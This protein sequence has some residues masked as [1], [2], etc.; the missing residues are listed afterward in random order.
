MD[1]GA[2]GVEGWLGT[3][4]QSPSGRLSFP[5]QTVAW[6]CLGLAPGPWTRPC[7]AE[8]AP[9][10]LPACTAL[11]WQS[12]NG[13]PSGREAPSFC[14]TREGNP[15]ACRVSDGGVFCHHSCPL[16]SLL[17]SPPACGSAGTGMELVS[18]AVQLSTSGR[19]LGPAH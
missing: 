7:L 12:E 11:L 14:P 13:A 8:P 3:Q 10:Q 17:C 1:A 15:G 16:P 2:S 6:V 5:P 19:Q 18:P 9:G 4:V